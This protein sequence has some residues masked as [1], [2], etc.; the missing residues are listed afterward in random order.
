M[1]LHNQLVSTYCKVPKFSDAK[2]FAVINPEFK[3]RGQTF[4]VFCQNEANPIAYNE[5]P[6]QT[7]PLEAV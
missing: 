3:Q 1:L 2:N 6:D 4:R 5:D 7:T